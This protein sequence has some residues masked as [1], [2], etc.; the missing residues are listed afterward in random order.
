MRG[1][2]GLQLTKRNSRHFHYGYT[3]R[4]KIGTMFKFWSLEPS[5]K[6]ILQ[7]ENIRNC[8][9]LCA[10]QI[11]F[12]TYTVVRRSEASDYEGESLSIL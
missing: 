7:S 6:S 10:K 2:L 8:K 9:N 11:I 4:K 12:K 1:E 3:M 5:S